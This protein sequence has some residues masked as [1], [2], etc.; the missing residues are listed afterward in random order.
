MKRTLI[1]V[2][3]V[4]VFCSPVHAIIPVSDWTQ[5]AG[6]LRELSQ[7]IR[8]YEQYIKQTALSNT[9]LLEAYKRYDQMLA[10]YQQALR[11]A[12]RLKATLQGVN[13]QNFLDNLKN[14]DLYDPRYAS[15]DD[16]NVGS[17][18][19]DDAVERNK[20]LNGWGM[21]DQEWSEMNAAIP[22][23]GDDRERAKAIFQYRKRKA[24]MSI[25]Q[26]VASD[27]FAS[28]IVTQA[29]EAQKTKDALESLGDND[30]LATQQLIARQQQ[31][32]IEQNLNQQAQTNTD[33]K[34][35]NQVANDYFNKMARAR[36]IKEKAMADAYKGDD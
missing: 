14:I 31:L 13:L 6:Q 19:W 15:G 36:A 20:L 25:Q 16:P 3:L 26:D 9:Q 22:Y 7:G 17:K 24:E 35:S 23:T 18:P 34:M 5:I 27:N 33:F 2:V 32:L 8:D 11:E 21:S 30:S 28:N 10:D 4:G 29:K 12:E 1:A